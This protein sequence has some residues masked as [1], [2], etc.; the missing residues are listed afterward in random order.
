MKDICLACRKEHLK[1]KDVDIIGHALVIMKANDKSTE[2]VEIYLDTDT[3][4]NKELEDRCNH[5]N[6]LNN[7]SKTYG[8]YERV[9]VDIEKLIPIYKK[10]DG[11]LEQCKLI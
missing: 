2:V 7:N 6:N 4:F 10:K 9:Y 1:S 8:Y 5:L 11:V 3:L